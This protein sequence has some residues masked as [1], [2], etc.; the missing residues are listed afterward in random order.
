MVK[1][2]QA[3]P[4]HHLLVNGNG[5]VAAFGAETLTKFATNK[6]LEHKITSRNFKA[7]LDFSDNYK[8]KTARAKLCGMFINQVEK[9]TPFINDLST[10]GIEFIKKSWQNPDQIV[11]SMIY[12]HSLIRFA[13]RANSWLVA[14][15]IPVAIRVSPYNSVEVD[16]VEF[17][18]APSGN[19][20]STLHYYKI[21]CFIPEILKFF[22]ALTKKASFLDSNAKTVARS[23]FSGF[24]GV[25]APVRNRPS[26]RAA[27]SIANAARNV[28][29]S[30]NSDS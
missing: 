16:R 1:R 29:R 9:E 12:D 11:V 20:R 25:P 22:K 21:L 7:G 18:I 13:R 4:A 23:K 17:H 30:R 14:K 15:G 27:Q 26:S 8:A 19:A 6:L 24:V 2:V 28:S 5:F 3:P 10:V